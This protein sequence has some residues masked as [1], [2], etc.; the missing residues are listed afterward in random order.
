[1]AYPLG[2]EPR[3]HSITET[4]VVTRQREFTTEKET[5]DKKWK[6]AEEKLKEEGDELSTLDQVKKDF[7][8]TT[9]K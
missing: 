3:I 4:L 8:I 5:V 1:M 9:V 6:A 2:A 7:E